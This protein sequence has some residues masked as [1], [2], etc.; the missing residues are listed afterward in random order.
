MSALRDLDRRE[1][2]EAWGIV[3]KLKDDCATLIKERDAARAEIE[4]L[5]ACLSKANAGME[6]ME[7]DLYLKL[8]AVEV[9]RDRLRSDYC[10]CVVCGAEL[11]PPDAPPHCLDCHPTE[12]HEIEWEEARA[13]L[14][15]QGQAECC[16][17]PGGMS[18]GCFPSADEIR[19]EVSRP[20]RMSDFK[21]P[22]PGE[23]E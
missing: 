8:N 13:A 22:K 2:P 21:A 11:L 9:E 23:G 6:E 14:R 17:N 18:N 12:E 16:A 10:T 7:R 19:A 1:H 3:D 5:T 4:R 15:E 20:P